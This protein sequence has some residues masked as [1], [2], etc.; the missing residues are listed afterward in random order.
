MR[1]IV[2]GA[3]SAAA[4]LG[5]LAGAAQAQT[6][7]LYLV[8]WEPI[9]FITTDVTNPNY[10]GNTGAAAI[11]LLNG[12]LYLAGFNNGGASTGARTIGIA[13]I[14]N[15]FG[16]SGQLNSRVT[17]IAD[18]GLEANQRFISGIDT[19]RRALPGGG[20]EGRLVAALETNSTSASASNVKKWQVWDIETPNPSAPIATTDPLALNF[21]AG[22][23]AAWDFGATGQ[24]IAFPTN[25]SPRRPIAAFL[26]IGGRGPLGFDVTPGLVMSASNPNAYGAGFASDSD[27]PRL[28]ANGEGQTFF[29]DMWIHR[30]NGTIAARADNTVI[31]VNRNFDRYVAGADAP[32]SPPTP[33]AP[34]TLAMPA[35]GTSDYGYWTFWHYDSSGNALDVNGNIAAQSGLPPSNP[36]PYENVANRVTTPKYGFQQNSS[37]SNRLNTANQATAFIQQCVAI[38]EGSSPEWL[39][40]NNRNT[41][42]TQSL[43]AVIKVNQLSDGAPAT[44]NFVGPDGQPITTFPYTYGNLTIADGAGNYD[45]AWDRD[46]KVLAISDITNKAVYF[47]STVQ[48]G[49]CVL[50]GGSCV[51]L[52]ASACTSARVGGT[53]GAPGSVCAVIACCDSATGA[54]TLIAQ[55][56]CA[57]SVG[58]SGSCSPN[59]CPQPGACCDAALTC[60]AGLSTSCA[61]G[62]VFIPGGAC[63][64]NPCQ[65]P[66]VCCA[67]GA[68]S[69][70]FQSGCTGTWSAGGSCSP[71]PCAP[72]TVI[73]CRGSTCGVVASSACTLSGSTQ[74]GLLNVGAGAT[75]NASGN[76]RQ[77]CCK[78]DYNKQ[79]GIEL[80]DIFAFL[81]DWFGN[82]A[83]ADFNGQSGVDLLDIFAFLNAW[84]A[85]GC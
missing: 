22:G 42:S 2:T 17:L 85:G 33:M 78:A 30:G 55:Q 8:K 21:R 39:V 46:L 14:N 64:V 61:A 1:R 12:D 19:Y 23:G 65:A 16:T 75:C 10:I 35:V 67:A 77:P 69:V 58:A 81:N 52:P 37:S 84:F 3:V 73:C 44:V 56:F 72:S 5:C 43:G 38:T 26:P 54:C 29:R 36:V 7:N 49:S 83:Y 15:V 63:T 45:F 79:G 70:T 34:S 59:A 41:S 53:A 6:A 25:A 50:P 13:R 28:V 80:L 82:V 57:G 48:P 31:V 4:A 18:Y 74:A 47:F 76:D 11:S 20:F 68:C 60:T 71:S 40:W 24:G 51:L 66:G 9:N 62:S 32:P 27:G